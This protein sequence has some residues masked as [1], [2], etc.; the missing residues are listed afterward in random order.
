M[1]NIDQ[2]KKN[3]KDEQ[4]RFPQ[5]GPDGMA[6][7]IIKG[8]EKFRVIAS[9]GARWDH[10]SVSCADRCPTWDEMCWFKD[11]FFNPEEEAMQLHPAKKNYINNH[12]FCLHIW[13][14]QRQS[15]PL[16]PNKLTGVK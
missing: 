2:I 8:N 16:P 11:I 9:W 4:I 1:Y 6:F 5:D 13:K 7:G 15:I 3:L 10:V 14:P 12:P